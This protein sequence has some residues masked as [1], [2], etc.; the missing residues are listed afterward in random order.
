MWYWG[1]PRVKRKINTV[2][3]SHL[4]LELTQGLVTDRVLAQSAT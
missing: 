4:A 3:A 1:N 2:W